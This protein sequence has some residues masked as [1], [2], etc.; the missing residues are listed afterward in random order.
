MRRLEDFQKRR[1]CIQEQEMGSLMIHRVRRNARGFTLIE[2]LVVIAIFAILASLLLPA[3]TKA[4]T[5]AN[6]TV[7][8]SNLRQLG[9]ALT[10]YV[11]DH[12]GYPTEAVIPGE[13]GL[14]GQRA[15]HNP[16]LG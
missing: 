7:C 3:L 5:L 8:K 14:V 15:S 13:T 10:L 6:S 9:L 11:N 1:S 16:Q 2:L 4:K 12:N